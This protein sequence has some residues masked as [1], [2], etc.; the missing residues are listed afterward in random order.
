MEDE[1]NN[2]ETTFATP[3]GATLEAV[4]LGLTARGKRTQ[5]MA[6]MGLPAPM[7]HDLLER[8]L[9]ANCTP[10]KALEWLDGE[11]AA[12]SLDAPAR[13]SF[14]RFVKIVKMEL[15]LVREQM[16]DEPVRE[17]IAQVTQG[18]AQANG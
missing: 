16:L 18:D 14:Y 2:L 17:L 4:L 13:S 7:L 8:L 1:S 11:C 10:D 9:T 6:C 3:D 5:Q 12:R 15:A